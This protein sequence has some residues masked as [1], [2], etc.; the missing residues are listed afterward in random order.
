[1]LL[2]LNIPRC[3]LQPQHVEGP[4]VPDSIFSQWDI[5]LSMAKSV[6]AKKI[7]QEPKTVTMQLLSRVEQLEEKIDLLTQ[8]VSRKV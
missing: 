3:E 8:A 2:K 7:E 6:F 5:I 1:M 4:P